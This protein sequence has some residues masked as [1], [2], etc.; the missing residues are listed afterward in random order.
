MIILKA[1]G[2]FFVK[3]WRWI[4]ETAWVQ[5]L[6]IVGAIF[7]VIFSIPYIMSWV[8]SWQ[9]SG[10]GAF[11]NSYSVSL[12]GE[13]LDADSSSE[14]DA[15]TKMVYQYS[16]TLPEEKGTQDIDYSDIINEYGEKF[17]I[18]YVKDDNSESENAEKGFKF[19]EEHWDNSYY[20]LTPHDDSE[21]DFKLY[22]IN[23]SEESSNDDDYDVTANGI[24]A[25]ERYLTVHTDLFNITGET[26]M[27][28]PYNTRASI[29]D[30]K[31]EAYMLNPTS[32]SSSA[33]SDFPIPTIILCDFSQKAVAQSRAGVSEVLFGISGDNDSD[34]AKLLMQMWNH[35]DAYSV[36]INNLFTKTA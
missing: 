19:L 24:S 11:Y 13:T 29:D 2:A 23:A 5:P 20:N 12:D 26:L 10:A 32:S 31:Y 16:V 4:R 7:A 18:A 33:L 3:I 28:A 21:L 36:D 15:L 22:V 34:K 9:L 14:A 25:F 30:S 35:T 1:I 8:E 17:Y 27:D 6:L